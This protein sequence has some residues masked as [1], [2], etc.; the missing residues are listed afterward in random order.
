MALESLKLSLK[1]QCNTQEKAT[2]KRQRKAFSL[3]LTLLSVLLALFVITISYSIE[4]LSLGC[5]ALAFFLTILNSIYDLMKQANPSLAEILR[6][7]IVLLCIPI[8]GILALAERDQA[9]NGASLAE[10]SQSLLTI[11]IG[12]FVGIVIIKPL[13]K[14]LG[15]EE[16]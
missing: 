4:C 15:D 14:C 11:A 12:F 6:N 7:L 3:I 16:R 10:L 5:G 2:F 1:L 8:F 9:E 13:T